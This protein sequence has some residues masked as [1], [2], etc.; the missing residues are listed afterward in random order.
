LNIPLH[1][2]FATFEGMF[3]Y[4]VKG[5]SQIKNPTLIISTTKDSLFSKEIEKKLSKTIKTSK[6][7][8]K[9]GTHHLVIQKPGEV[10]KEIE[11]FIK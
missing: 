9:E 4:K 11:K 6:H 8:I 2:A 3:N 5:I 1:S 7:I 10:I